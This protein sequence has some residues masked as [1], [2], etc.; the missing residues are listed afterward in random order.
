VDDFS[1]LRGWAEA[2]E[3]AQ[4][5][6][7]AMENRLRSMSARAEAAEA[8]LG[9]MKTAERLAALEMRRSFRKA[10][11]AVRAW[12]L[13]TPGLGEHL[14]ARL[15]GA[16]GHPVIASPYHWTGEG[17]HRRLVPDP[18][19]RRTVSQLWSYCGHGDPARRK[20][21][22]M[23]AEEAFTLGNPR[24]KMLVRLIAEGAMKCA[25]PTAVL[26]GPTDAA[27]TDA[28]PLPTSLRIGE[29]HTSTAGWDPS[30]DGG[31]TDA[32]RAGHHTPR[33][34]SPYRDVYDL[35]RVTYADRV[36]AKG[37]PWTPA[38]QHSA[39]LRLTGKRILQDLYDVAKA[40]VQPTA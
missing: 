11:P 26:P 14:F 2:F 18:P 32:P 19:Y 9:G 4:K 29:T 30:S 1:N 22:G 8:I 38:H 27:N 35:G 34:R 12:V 23:T 10:A 5:S 21:K 39:A 36:D 33:R 20:R 24:A 40:E 28:P 3:D 25:G 17:E 15:I 7:V 16:I 6:R 13:E 37:E 31:A